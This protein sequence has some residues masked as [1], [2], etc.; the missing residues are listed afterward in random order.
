MLWLDIAR[1]YM[2]SPKSHSV[3]NIIAFVSVIAIAIP[4]AATIILLSMFGGLDST[5]KEIYST[6]DA[7]MEI[8][9]IRGKNFQQA[10]IDYNA[11]VAIDGVCGYTSYIE[12]SVI[13]STV[14]YR[15]AVTLRGIDT[16]YANV[17]T[18]NRH[19]TKGSLESI[20]RGDILAGSTIAGSLGIYNAIGAE[21]EL[22]ALNRSDISS[23]LPMSGVT[24]MKSS[25]GGIISANAEL[26]AKLVL[27]ELT[28]TQ[29]L[30]N[31]PGMVTHVALDIEDGV[32]IPRI[33]REI[34]AVVGD[35]FEVK[36]R[37]EKNASM[38][39]IMELEK[40]AIMLIGCFIAI[41][42]AFSMVGSVVMLLTEKRGDIVILRAM[43][44]NNKLIR[45]IFVGEGML[46]SMSG[47][48][49]GIIL[50][51]GFC[52][53]QLYYGLIKIEGNMV[54]DSYPIKIDALDVT[55]VALTMVCIG[56]IISQLTVRATLKKYKQH[57][58]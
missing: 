44:V 37:E 21:V 10:A 15:N 53:L 40:F 16:N 7:D 49:I 4:T 3:I 48:L 51:I 25:L 57:D 13:I 18:V 20:S 9:S 31:S 36:T 33:K 50:G 12:Q 1:R 55:I 45:R 8:T 23:M 26:D 39:H 56:W 29:E 52:L 17:L 58:E 46:L 32:N 27:M 6:A 38:T 34:K 24:R 2:F 42:A 35:S 43:G 14:G 28:R 19:I 22:S 30:L 41:I 5:I 54:I 47:T 11:I